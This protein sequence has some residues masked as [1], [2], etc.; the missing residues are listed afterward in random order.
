[1]TEIL[2]KDVSA[3]L[4]SVKIIDVRRPDEFTGELGHI[5]GATLVTLETDL[6][7]YLK[8]LPKN[9]AYVFVC[10]SG[11]R[12]GAATKLAFQMGLSN[13]ANMVGG[14]MAWNAAGLGIER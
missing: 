11:G 9:D 2:P 8:N 5:P 14:M 7:T 6:E 3:K 4:S 1:M 13:V 12:S 10:K